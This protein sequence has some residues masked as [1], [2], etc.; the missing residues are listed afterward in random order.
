MLWSP[1]HGCDVPHA[2][3]V[4]GFQNIE[5]HV[6]NRPADTDG[7]VLVGTQRDVPSMTIGHSR[8]ACDWLYARIVECHARGE[9]VVLTIGRDEAAWAA[10]VGAAR[11]A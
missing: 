4:P 10:F 7:C 11:V 8:A 2:L 1:K 3:D 6:G 5:I 9:A